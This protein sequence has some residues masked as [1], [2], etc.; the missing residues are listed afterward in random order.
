MSSTVDTEPQDSDTQDS[1]SPNGAPVVSSALAD[2]SGLEVGDTQDISLSG[3]FSDADS[4]ALTITAASSDEAVATVAVASDGSSLTVTG[5]TEGS[6]AITV[7]AQDGDGS[8]VSDAFDVSVV[9]KYTALIAQVR[10]W[11]NDPQLDE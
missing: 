10:Q 5:V 9:A 11:R 3:V 1:D 4:D 2:V 8:S 7:T 6:A